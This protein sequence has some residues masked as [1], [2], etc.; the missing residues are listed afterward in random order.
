MVR[1]L[2]VRRG[3]DE[4]AVVLPD[5]CL[6]VIVRDGTAQ[7][8]GPDTGPVGVTLAPQEVVIGVRLRP[9]AGGAALGVD[10]E[11]LRDRRVALEDLWGRAGREAGERAGDD[12]LALVAVLRDRLRRAAP[13][14]A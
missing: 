12:P 11:E 13:D 9:G 5:G 7:V 10:A 3:A 8:A 6:D 2:W 1:C 4:R 14:P